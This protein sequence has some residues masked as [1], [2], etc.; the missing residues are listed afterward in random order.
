MHFVERFKTEKKN[1]KKS[2]L[3]IAESEVSSDTP[4]KMFLIFWFEVLF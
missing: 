4:K 3:P 1:E 2:V